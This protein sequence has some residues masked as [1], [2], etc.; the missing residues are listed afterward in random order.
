MHYFTYLQYLL[1][2]AMNNDGMFRYCMQ[3]NMTHKMF[4][5]FLWKSNVRES[6]CSG[7]GGK[8]LTEVRST[9][10]KIFLSS[11]HPF[12]PL[13][14]RNYE[15]YPYISRVIRQWKNWNNCCNKLC[16][17]LRGVCL[18]VL[19]AERI[20]LRG[21][22]VFFQRHVEKEN[23]QQHGIVPSRGRSLICCQPH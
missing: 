20:Y 1:S 19:A 4:T 14:S 7:L 15:N 21:L 8:T 22:V 18:M 11:A 6:V 9:R 2:S 16:G 23:R 13:P 5:I 10:L 12:L 3:V 17:G